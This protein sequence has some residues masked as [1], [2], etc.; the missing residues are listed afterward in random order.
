MINFFHFFKLKNLMVL[1]PLIFGWMIYYQTRDNSIR[2]N[3]WTEYIGIEKHNIITP[4][5]FKYNLPDGIFA[6]SF[7][8]LFFLVWGNKV[9]KIWIVICISFLFL[10]EILQGIWIS[11]TFDFFDLIFIIL[12]I[13]LSI[14][15]NYIINLK[16]KQHEN[17][18]IS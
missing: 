11:G 18:T 8:N 6:F 9:P 13:E 16:Q 12:G 14:F 7:L 1:L 2:L 3:Q 17:K 15:I 10:S 5:W 4:Y